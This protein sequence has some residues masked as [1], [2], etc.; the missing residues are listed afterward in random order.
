MHAPIEV[1]PRV[2]FGPAEVTFREP[3][4]FTHIVNCEATPSATSNAAFLHIG[5]RHF[6]FLKS[7]D[8]DEFPILIRHLQPLTT[9]VDDALTDPSAT[10]LIHCFAG[11]NRS[12]TLAIAYAAQKTETPATTMVHQIR[13]RY[14]RLIVTNDG[15]YAQLSALSS[16]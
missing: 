10:V 2:W 5:P 12:A 1:T 14:R 11:Q 16:V 15:F 9:F 6:C 8:E 4:R 7:Y 13:T 3:T